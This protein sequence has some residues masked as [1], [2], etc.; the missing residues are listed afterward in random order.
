MPITTSLVTAPKTEP[1][2]LQDIKNHLRLDIDF[3]TEQALLESYITA[4]RKL[5]GQDRHRGRQRVRKV[6]HDACRVAERPEQRRRRLRP[7]RARSAHR[8]AFGL[9]RFQAGP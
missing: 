8:G 5:L 9:Y 2:E 4:A 6:R 3:E 7:R 1:I